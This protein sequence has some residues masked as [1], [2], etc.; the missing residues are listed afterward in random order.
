[1]LKNKLRGK[2]YLLV[3]DGYLSVSFNDWKVLSLPFHSG[4]SGSTVIITT[5][6]DRVSSMVG[7]I[8]KYYPK[9]ITPRDCWTI[10]KQ[11]A[12]STEDMIKSE[13]LAHV[14]RKI[15]K[16]C[17]GLPLVAVSLG[18]MLSSNFN[19]NIWES[20][21]RSE[22]WNLPLR[23]NGSLSLFIQNFCRLPNNL[24]M[25]FLYCSLFPPDHHF[26]MDDVVRLWVAEGFIHPIEEIRA[27]QIGR[28]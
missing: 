2:K 18:S 13:R 27:E 17:C 15:A 11:Y 9:L 28:N 21:S 7:S 10:M 4:K 22:L 26:E 16:K 1:K 19:L 6:S 3:L 14:G 25:C 24:K 5:Q 23:D 12:F 20:M 8:S